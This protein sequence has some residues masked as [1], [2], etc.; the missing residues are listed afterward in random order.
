MYY[1]YVL[2]ILTN[3]QLVVDLFEYLKATTKIYRHAPCRQLLQMSERDAKARI[4]LE[5]MRSAC[6]GFC[7][8]EAQATYTFPGFVFITFKRHNEQWVINGKNCAQN[9]L[10]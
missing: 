5:S 3:N 1:A 4:D 8:R 10:E 9:N 7:S 2:C 6:H